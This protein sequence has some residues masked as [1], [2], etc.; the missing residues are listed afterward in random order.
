MTEAISATTRKKGC[1]G[2]T[3]A[4]FAARPYPSGECATDGRF[5]TCLG[6]DVLEGGGQTAQSIVAIMVGPTQA[7]TFWPAACLICLRYTPL[8]AILRHCRPTPRIVTEDVI[9]PRPYLVRFFQPMDGSR[10]HAP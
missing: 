8:G 5:S 2:L 7:E 3:P 4:S 6:R 10:R 1:T 9:S